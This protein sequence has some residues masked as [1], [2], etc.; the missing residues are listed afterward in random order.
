LRWMLVLEDSDEDR[1][2]LG[3]GL[4]YDWVISGKEIK[5]LQAPTRWGRVDFRMQ[6]DPEKKHI[7]ARVEL[8]QARTPLEIQ[9]K[10]RLP[11]GYSLQS[12]TVNRKPAGFSGLH[13]D[14]VTVKSPGAKSV[15][16]MVQ[17]AEP[18]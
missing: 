16:I 1:L 18:A 15:E 4:P 3:K 13:G 11:R 8:P 7:L 14:T 2:Y 12:A 5:I 10:F 6:A 9:V 17:F